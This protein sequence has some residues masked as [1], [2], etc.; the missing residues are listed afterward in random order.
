MKELLELR[1]KMKARKPNFVREDSHKKKKLRKSGW[2]KP[3]GLHSKLRHKFK[4]HM[5]TVNNGF[6]SPNAVRGLHR[7]GLK[8][9]VVRNILQLKKINPKTD[10]III[11]AIGLRKK[12]EIIKEAQLLK[13]TILNVKDA[14]KFLEAVK[15]KQEKKK[16]DKEAKEK[17]NKKEEKKEEKKEIKEEK[18]EEVAE[19]DKKKEEKKEKDKILIKRT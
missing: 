18:K 17:E 9:I 15:E 12:I 11:G 16:K 7:L 3:K 8:Q 14:N 13:I 6:R 2:R 5:T 4:G 19:E 1:R 10:G